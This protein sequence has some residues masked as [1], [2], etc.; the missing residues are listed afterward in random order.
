[1]ATLCVFFFFCRLVGSEMCI[2]DSAYTGSEPAQGLWAAAALVI[3]G[4]VLVVGG[5]VRRRRSGSSSSS[6]VDDGGRS[7]LPRGGRA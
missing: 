6:P 4:V 3:A 7:P 2:R 1:M 5:G